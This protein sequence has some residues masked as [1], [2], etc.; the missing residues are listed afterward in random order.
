MHDYATGKKV[1]STKSATLKELG[2]DKSS[3]D[4]QLTSPSLKVP[5]AID[6][7]WV[8]VLNLP[9]DDQNTPWSKTMPT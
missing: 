4:Q 8:E 3:I 9:K 5:D 1:A 6:Y 2:F 7:Y